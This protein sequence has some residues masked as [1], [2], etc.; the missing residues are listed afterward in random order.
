MRCVQGSS[1]SMEISVAQP[2][3]LQASAPHPI[4]GMLAAYPLAFFTA[5]L[6]TDIAYAKTAQMQWANFSVWLITGGVI[7]GFFAAIAG[8]VDALVTRRAK[9]RS[10]ALH[11]ILTISTF[12]VA[13]INGFIHSRDAWTSVVPAGLL[14]SAITTALVLFTSWTGYSRTA[15]L[16]EG[17]N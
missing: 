2:T 7:M 15:P 12:V 5:A 3:I 13:I 9:E 1:I 11:S 4:H 6:L 8:I 14:L 10:S 16:R 17:L